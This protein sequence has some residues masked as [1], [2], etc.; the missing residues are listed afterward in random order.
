MI[1]HD[2]AIAG[3]YVIEPERL[4]DERG[5]F[6]RIWSPAALESKGLNPRI[7]HMSVSF[8][9]RKGTL[10]GMHYQAEP[11]AEAKI[12]RC[13]QGAIHD[14]ALDLRRASPTFLRWVAFELTASNR[15]MLYIPEGLAHG[16][17]TLRDETEVLYAIGEEYSPQH[18]RGVRWN[19]PA[20]GIAWPDD[21]RTMNERDRSYPDFQR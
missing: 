2:T 15:R 3:V 20:F 18:A 9:H 17:Q 19:D 13:T 11:M 1:F 16:F 21:T 14:V 8:N 4:E 10:R 5:F 6:A 7:A 12:V